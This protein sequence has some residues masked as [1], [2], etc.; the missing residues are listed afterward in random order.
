MPAWGTCWCRERRKAIT[1]LVPHG[2]AALQIGAPSRGVGPQPHTVPFANVMCELMATL[3]MTGPFLSHSM[4][5]MRPCGL[6]T[7]ATIDAHM[8]N[9]LKAMARKR[10]DDARAAVREG[11]T[12]S[13]V[14]AVCPSVMALAC[15]LSLH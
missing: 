2:R 1:C 11:F 3:P 10:G 4:V 13:F 9:I 6:R 8:V 5:G 7:K 12:S 15:S 14:L